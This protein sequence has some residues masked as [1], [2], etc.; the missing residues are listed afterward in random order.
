[1]QNG[2]ILANA[3]DAEQ[4]SKEHGLALRNGAVRKRLVAEG[5]N[6]RDHTSRFNLPLPCALAHP[7]PSTANL[8]FFN[9]T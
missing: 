8:L 3:A 5:S 6:T 1:L 4:H 9:K 7:T 2:V